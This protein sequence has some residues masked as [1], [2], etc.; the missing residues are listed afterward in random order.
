MTEINDKIYFLSYLIN[1][2]RRPDRLLKFFGS[3]KNELL[4]INIFEAIDGKSLNKKDHK[5][6]TTFSTGDYN[7]RSGIV[8]CAYSHIELWTKFI[9]DYKLDFML[10]L[11]DDAKLLPNFKDNFFYLLN[12]YSN[13]FDILFLH[14]HPYPQY[15]EQLKPK[16]FN[17]S[18][19]FIERWNK[20]M[21]CNLSMGGTTGYIITKNGALNMLKHIQ[22]Y[23][24]YNA[25]DWVMH[26]TADT[27]R[28]CYAFPFL[29]T[30]DCYTN[31]NKIDTD[32]Q[33]DYHNLKLTDEEW[34]NFEINDLLKEYEEYNLIFKNYNNQTKLFNLV[35]P[36]YKNKIIN[37]NLKNI[38]ISF[39]INSTDKYDILILLK[40][41][42]NN[43][44]LKQYCTQHYYT[45]EIVIVIK[46]IFI[47]EYLKNNKIF[48]NNYL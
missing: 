9:K 41:D 13:D 12:N 25:I 17:T 47:T 7:Y 15:S 23:G 28:I 5:I 34:N 26:K 38:I 46:D 31:E 10:V 14:F 48:G 39:D 33:N 30:A 19:P 20:S 6:Q 27:Q 40:K 8:G 29:V 18:T 37:N 36:K 35:E 24:M 3:N 21:C 16:I 4:P 2:K 32:I 11:E 43:L 44:I 22:N 45:N 1:L 42:I